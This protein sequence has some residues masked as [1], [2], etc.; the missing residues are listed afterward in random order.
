MTCS[1]CVVTPTIGRPSLHRMLSIL[2]PQMSFEDEVR[3]IG[4]GPQPSARTICERFPS[5]KYSEIPLIRNYGNPQR[6]LAIQE[7]TAD[8][9]MFIDDDDVP[10]DL[11][12]FD[13]RAA[14]RDN[15]GRPLMFRMYHQDR[16][17]WADKNVRVGNVSGQMFV[18]PNIKDRIGKWSGKYAADFDFI[19]STII[20]QPEKLDSVVWREE[21]IAHQGFAGP[22]IYG[23]EI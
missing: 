17:I 5:V 21:I 19:T 7:T 23:R 11:A 2:Q 15:P 13:V 1:I 3:V 12:L 16:V 6:N 10:K 14:V 9:I 22:G 20:L 8:I 18:V 4:D